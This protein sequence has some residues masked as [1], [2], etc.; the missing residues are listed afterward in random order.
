MTLR[1]RIL[2]VSLSKGGIPKLAVPSA[3]AESL[4]LE[5]DV[6]RD[7]QIHGGPRRALLLISA[8]VLAELRADGFPVSPGSLGENLTVT[9]L[10]FRELRAGMRFRAGGAIIELTKPRAPCANLDVYNSPGRRIQER[11]YDAQAKAGDPASPCWA[12]GGFYAA[13]AASGLIQAEDILELLD[14][15]V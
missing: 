12:R 3:W 9:G 14:L 1:G 2:Q 6:Q 4:G 10:D 7:M 13:V 11:L 8:E 5:G 15:A